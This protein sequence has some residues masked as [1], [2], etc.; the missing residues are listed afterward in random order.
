M[1][2]FLMPDGWIIPDR[3]LVR[4]IVWMASEHGR[5]EYRRITAPLR[6]VDWWVN[7]KRVEQIWWLAPLPRRS[8]HSRPHFAAR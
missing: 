2:E 1:W 8:T 4:R 3:Q 6:A 7:H 5:Y